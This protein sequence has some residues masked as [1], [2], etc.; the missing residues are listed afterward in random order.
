MILRK[1]YVTATG[2][3][4]TLGATIYAFNE[5]SAIQKAHEN[6]ERNNRYTYMKFPLTFKV[7]EI[8]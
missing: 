2:E 3:D 4:N 7:E 8:E 6:M 5:E 1:Y